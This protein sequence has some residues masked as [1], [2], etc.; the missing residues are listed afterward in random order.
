MLDT[1]ADLFGGD[2]IKKVHARQFIS[3]LRGL[4]IEFNVTV[5]LLSHPSQAGMSSGSGMSETPHG[6]I[7]CARASISSGALKVRDGSED[8]ATFGF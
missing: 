2:E 4:A 5:L 3:M 6:T 7:R 1:L 8:D